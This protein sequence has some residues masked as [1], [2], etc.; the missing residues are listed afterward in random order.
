MNKIKA[1]LIFTNRNGTHEK[2]T[3][4]V[5]T[6]GLSNSEI[7]KK[8]YEKYVEHNKDAEENILSTKYHRI[9]DLFDWKLLN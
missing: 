8:A 9:Y 1:T 2:R 4:I 3:Y 7:K 6:E 5:E